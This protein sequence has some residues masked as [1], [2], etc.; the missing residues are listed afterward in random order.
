M[1][2]PKVAKPPS[3]IVNLTVGVPASSASEVA[4]T[5]LPGEESASEI[6]SLAN[7]I[8]EDNV[9]PSPSSIP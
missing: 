1:L 5:I 3:S 4:K 9:S 7:S 6:A 8:Y 2:L